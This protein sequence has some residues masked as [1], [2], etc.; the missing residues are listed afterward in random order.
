MKKASE[1]T[2]TNTVVKNA[3]RWILLLAQPVVR[4]KYQKKTVH[5]IRVDAA[6]NILGGI[7]SIIVANDAKAKTRTSLFGHSITNKPDETI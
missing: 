1:A 2:Y 5:R 4:Q 6:N 3:P 7:Y